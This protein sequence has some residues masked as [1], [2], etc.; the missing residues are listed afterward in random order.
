MVR[1]SMKIEFKG[2]LPLPKNENQINQGDIVFCKGASGTSDIWGVC[3]TLYDHQSHKYLY[4][5][6]SFDGGGSEYIKGEK[7]FLN[8]IYSYWT[9]IKRIPFNK[10]KLT[11]EE[12]E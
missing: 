1:C 2:N 6:I 5:I 11:I 3:T 8:E 9:I 4:R 12:M 10:V 7:L